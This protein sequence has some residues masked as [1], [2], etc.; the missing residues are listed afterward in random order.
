MNPELPA[1]DA[2]LLLADDDPDDRF[3]ILR[4]LRRSRPEIKVATV[5]DGVELLAYLRA[6]GQFGRVL[7]RV[8]LLDLNMPRLDGR[9]VLSELAAD[10][11]LR[12]LPVVVLSTSTEAEEHR[13]ALVLGATA[14]ISKPA[15]FSRLTEVLREVTDR[16]LGNQEPRLGAAV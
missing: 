6:L 9:E 14:F 1:E 4:A 15:E 7:P 5:R 3:L 12:G 2:E 13:R 10:P 16:W 11:Q 8:L